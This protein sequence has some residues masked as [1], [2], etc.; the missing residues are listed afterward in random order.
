MYIGNNQNNVRV[1]LSIFIRNL[2]TQ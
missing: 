2:E 1:R